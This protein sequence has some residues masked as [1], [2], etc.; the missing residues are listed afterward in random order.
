MIAEIQVIP[1]PAGTAT[2]RYKHVDAAIAVIQASGL[3]YEVHAMGTVVEGPPEKV[4][5]LL[6]AVHQAT[7]EAGAE[8][9]LSVIKV[10]SAAQP[11]GP[12]VEDLVRKFRK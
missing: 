1:R 11:G 6:Q 10:S 4:W 3:R 5:T 8:R 9:T 12:R 7:L 2:D